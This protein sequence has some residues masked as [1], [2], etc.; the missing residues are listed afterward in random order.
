MSLPIIF[1]HTH[2]GIGD[3]MICNGLVREL[4]ERENAAITYLAVKKENYTSV[5]AMYADDSRIH[6]LPMEKWFHGD[7]HRIPMSL[8]QA[9]IASKVFISGFD[10][11]RQDWDVSFYDSVDVPF[12]KRWTSFKC[13]RNKEREAKLESIIN[14]NNEPF[15]LVHDEQAYAPDRFEFRTRNDLKIIRVKKVV[16]SDGW[17]DNLIDWYGMLEKATE[18]HCISSSVIHFAASIGRE[19]FFHDFGRCDAWGGN[20]VLP[21]SWKTIDERWR[22]KPH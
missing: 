22:L 3:H 20:F 4:T 9:K 5:S 7:P 11:C 21:S 18:I 12:E 14:P 2:Q 1:I 8:P 19:G 13:H 17:A 16:T 6:C 10:K 15:V